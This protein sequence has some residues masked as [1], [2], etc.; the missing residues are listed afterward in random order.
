MARDQHDLL[1]VADATGSMGNYLTSLSKS[2]PEILAL[3]RLSGLFSRVGVLV[4]RDYC[5]TNV[6]EWSGWDKSSEDLLA[7][8]SLLQ[9]DGGG[10]YP[11]AG[12][13]FPSSRV[14]PR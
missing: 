8:V 5:D 14:P 6:T 1:I 7:F 13:F 10:D 3:T 2:I 9:P 4:Y 12:A 11:E